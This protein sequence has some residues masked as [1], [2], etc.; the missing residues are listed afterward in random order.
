[1][2][3][4]LS[5][6][7]AWHVLAFSL[8]CLL[9]LGSAVWTYRRR[10]QYAARAFLLFLGVTVAWNATVLFRIVG[11]RSLAWELHLIEQFFQVSMTLTWFY[12]AAVYAGYRGVLGR[13]LVAYPLGSVAVG[14]LAVESFPPLAAAT[15]TAP[16]TIEDPFVFVTWTD[17]LPSELVE[18]LALAAFAAGSGLILYKLLT[19]NYVQ[20][21]QVAL[22]FVATSGAIL[23]E[24]VESAIP[25]AVSGVDYPAVAVTGVG[26]SFVVGLYRYDLFGYTPVDMSDVIDGITAPVLVLNPEQRVV[27]FN[28]P[29]KATFD[30]LAPGHKAE[31]VLPDP[32]VDALPVADPTTSEAEVTLARDG[33]DRIYRLYASSLDS[34]GDSQ[35]LAVTARDLTTRRRQQEDLDLLNQILTRA[36]RHNIRNEIDVL[37][38]NS[39][40]LIDQLDGEQRDRALAAAAAAEDLLSISAKARVMKEIVKHRGQTATVDVA[41]RVTEIVAE[42]ERTYPDTSFSLDCPASCSI[43]VTPD[44]THALDNLIEN[45]AEHNPGA[46]AEVWVTLRRDPDGVVIVIEDNGPGIPDNELTV[47]KRGY[48]DVLNHGSGLGLWIVTMVLDEMDGTIRYDTGE[49]GTTITLRIA[50]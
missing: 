39:R 17:T 46:D 45:A 7:F 26:V 31:A 22:V 3:P 32:V 24:V 2:I 9:G 43:T 30:S 8:V 21:W 23:S 10:D 28:A 48:E 47:L 37:R 16:T 42:C 49:D 20:A 12:F 27:D 18:V 34:F 1:M 36:L 50:D 38:A 6:V 44:T 5:G 13:P 25:Y 4:Q 35:G 14:M 41:D 29:A 33:E 15:N 40:E 11:P 19:A